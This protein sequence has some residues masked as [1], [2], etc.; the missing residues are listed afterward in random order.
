MDEEDYR[1]NVFKRNT[2]LDFKNPRY[3][4]DMFKYFSDANFLLV[5]SIKKEK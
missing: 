3:C 2:R 1:T 4:P 5:Q